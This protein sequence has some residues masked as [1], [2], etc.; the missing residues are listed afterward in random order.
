LLRCL[1]QQ[2]DYD[3]DDDDGMM[4]MMMKDGPYGSHSL[5]ESDRTS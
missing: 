3:D 1:F 4:M 2:E 5:T